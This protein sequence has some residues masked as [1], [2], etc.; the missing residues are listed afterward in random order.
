MAGSSTL[1]RLSIV[2]ETRTSIVE[3][4][5]E[6]ERRGTSGTTRGDVA[7][8]PLPITL[9]FLEAEERFEIILCK[10]FN[11]GVK[12]GADSIDSLKAKFKAWVG[13]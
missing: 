12:K 11:I 6:E 3:G 9:G 2:S 5:D 7:S 8:K 13:K 10:V 4:V 1:G